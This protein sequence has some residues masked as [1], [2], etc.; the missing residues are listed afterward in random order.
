VSSSVRYPDL[1]SGVPPAAFRKRSAYFRRQ[2]GSTVPTRILMKASARAIAAI[3]ALAAT[4]PVYVLLIL[5]GGVAALVL[6]VYIGIT[7]PAVW[8]ARPACR[9]AAAAVLR[10]I[11]NASTGGERL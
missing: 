6:L 7:L 4:L 3:G 1:H 11:L 8:S 2:H 5:C 9:K 10:Q